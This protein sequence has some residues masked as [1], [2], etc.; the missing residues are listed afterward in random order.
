MVTKNTKNTQ[1]THTSGLL[2]ALI[3][4]LVESLQKLYIVEYIKK[5]F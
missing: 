3:E 5:L 2:N 1:H 4:Y